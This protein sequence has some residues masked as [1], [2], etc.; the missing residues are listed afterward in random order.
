MIVFLFQ[1]HFFLRVVNDAGLAYKSSFWRLMM[2]GRYFRL[3]FRAASWKDVLRS[4]ALLTLLVAP[5]L[6]QGP[7][8]TIP[9]WNG[10][11]FISS[12]GVTNT[13]TYGETITVSAGASAL[14]SFAFEIGNCSAS[15]TFRGAIYA[16]DG[17]K[18]TGASLFE[19]ATTS[20]APGSTYTLVTFN[21]GGLVLP[22]GTYVLLASTSRDQS[23][24]PSSSC[25]WGSVG[26]NTA[27]AG[28]TFVYL[29]NGPNPSEWTT[30]TWST[31]AQDLAFQ[32]DG[33]VLPSSTPAQA[34]PAASTISLLI[35]FAA[36]AAV[37]LFQL[38]RQ[39]Q[40][41]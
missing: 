29:N 41:I 10:T 4:T 24:A 23:G 19:S 30:N 13:A 21:T 26:N 6:A 18:A 7:I 5:A 38:A 8:N 15:V 3:G 16:W 14:N 11:T 28:G 39:R 1:Y 17:T 34:A 36:L 25:R 32:V 40:A 2:P 37:G 27:Y 9:V 22:A 12:F 20:V 33:L 31:I 35:G